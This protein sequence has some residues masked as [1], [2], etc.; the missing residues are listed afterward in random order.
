MTHD[1]LRAKV[2]ELMASGGLPSERPV[3]Y[4]TGAGALGTRSDSRRRPPGTCLI[5]TEPG[6]TVS[7]VWTAGRMASLHAACDALWKQAQSN[8]A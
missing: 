8:S 3:I 7:Y 6:P 5:C 1:Q 4:G 2:S